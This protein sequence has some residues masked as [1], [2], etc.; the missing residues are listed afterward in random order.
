[1]RPKV[2]VTGHKNPDTDSICSALGYAFY[3]NRTDPTSVY[4]AVRGGELNDETRFVLNRFGFRVPPLLRSLMP[5]V[6]DIP[7]KRLVT[8][9]PSTRVG[10][11]AILMK[12]NRI[13]SLPVVDDALVVRGV[14]DAVDVATAYADQL[15]H[16]DLL[17]YVVEL[18]TLVRQ[19]EARVLIHTG[20]PE[21]L[22]GRLLVVTGS[23][24]RLVSAAEDV[25]IIIS[26]GVPRDDILQA[27]SAVATII[28][29]GGA[30]PANTAMTWPAHVS[31]VLETDMSVTQALRALWSSIP[32]SAFMEGTVPLL[33]MTD[34]LERAKKA[35]LDSSA[36]CAVVL[37]ASHHPV[38]IVTR[39]DLIR[40]SRKKVVLVDHN[41]T[42]Q[43]VDGVEEADILEIIDHHRVG[44]I[45]TFRPIY[46]YNEPVG[47]TCTIVAELCTENG[48][49]LPKS[50]A[51][52][53]LSG[54]LSDTMNL[55]LSTTTPKDVRAVRRLAATIGL[56]SEAYGLELLENGSVMFKGLAAADVLMRD[57]KEFVL[58]DTRIGVSQAV[59]FTFDRIR[60]REAEFKQAMNDL[61]N[62]MGL[63]MVAFL[64]T[65]PLSRRSYLIVAG[66]VE[67]YEEAFGVHVE[68][69]HAILDGV[70]S[71]KKDFIP[72]MADVLSRY[73]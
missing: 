21:Q 43:A 7:R 41:E 31:L 36:R 63:A 35:V 56:D 1:M 11:A 59:V 55:N 3:K 32:V 23:P 52:L 17:P 58:F 4:I 70:L 67:A 53:L 28:I 5:Q 2:I 47:S 54:I 39:S 34:T 12:E 27:C 22:K 44:D 48:V 50:V 49:F 61:K 18:D 64:A 6:Q 62:R 14:V 66:P 15:E 20:E 9:S 29:T 26:E 25:S 42:L 57:F 51:G 8:V 46:F 30:A 71:R 33:S 38:N 19:L 40:F 72:P 69:G 73:A 16:A 37:D 65:D 45:S 60:E 24:G 13:H 10:K 68:D